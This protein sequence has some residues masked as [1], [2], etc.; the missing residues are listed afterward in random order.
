MSLQQTLA[1]RL[2][3]A[4]F[5]LEAA[6]SVRRLPGGDG[7]AA[8]DAGFFAFVTGQGGAGEFFTALVAL[9]F[10]PD[11]RQHL[12]GRFEFG[13]AVFAFNHG[14]RRCF[15]LLALAIVVGELIEAAE[16]HA[17]GAN[18]FGLVGGFFPERGQFC[19][20]VPA[21]EDRG[22]PRRRVFC[23]LVAGEKLL[24]RSVF[25]H[26][27]FHVCLAFANLAAKRALVGVLV[28]EYGVAA[29]QFFSAVFAVNRLLKHVTLEQTMAPKSLFAWNAVIIKN[30]LFYCGRHIFVAVIAN[31]RVTLICNH[32]IVNYFWNGGRC[33]L[34][35]FFIPEAEHAMFSL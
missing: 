28:H 24:A 23:H 11:V 30:V 18:L 4:L 27:H 14:R 20:A 5:A 8:V 12:L 10:F 7:V 32:T 19:R 17:A 15:D 21:P 25:A 16:F 29:V 35:V 9:D 31:D 34:V 13:A 2:L 1:W 3:A 22:A 26:V 33:L 6:L